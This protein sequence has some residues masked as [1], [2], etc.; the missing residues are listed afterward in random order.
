[1]LG[2]AILVGSVHVNIYCYK[3]NEMTIKLMHRRKFS[4]L[5]FASVAISNSLLNMEIK[6]D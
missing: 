4:K 5:A 3:R 6:D 2:L 1:M